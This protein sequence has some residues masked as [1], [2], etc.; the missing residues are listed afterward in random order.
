MASGQMPLADVAPGYP[1][2]LKLQAATPGP[3]VA[4]VPAPVQEAGAVGRTNVLWSVLL[5]GVLVVAIMTWKL[6]LQLRAGPGH[7]P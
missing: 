3:A 5:L 7:D 4:Q 2:L 6:V 1:E